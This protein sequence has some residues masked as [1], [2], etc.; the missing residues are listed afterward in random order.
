IWHGDDITGATTFR[1]DEGMDTGPVY[2]IV[3]EAIRPDDTSG[4]LLARLADSGAGLLVS[5]LD[6]L[7]SG[8]VQAVAQ[9][10]EPSLAPKV[11]VADAR[12]RWGDPA[13]AVDRQLRACTPAPGAWTMLGDERLRLLP[14][15][16]VPEGP[17]LA[18]GLLLVARSEVL[19]GTA[20]VPVRLGLV[21]PAGRRA[22][23]AADWARGARPGDGARLA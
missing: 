3:T 22:M 15:Q 6:A 7:E 8:S 21:Q 19:V 10:G 16:P 14:V 18:P 4:S 13:R 12:V 23:P 20:T 2:G 5:T 11:D 1:L 17:D 9:A